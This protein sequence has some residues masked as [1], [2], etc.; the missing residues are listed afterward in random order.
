VRDRFSIG[1]GPVLPAE[2]YRLI[3]YRS[4]RKAELDATVS[5][6]KQPTTTPNA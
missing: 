4:T 6:G 2:R 1:D 3:W 5:T